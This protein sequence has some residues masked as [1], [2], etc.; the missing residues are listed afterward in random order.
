MT[1]NNLKL[2]RKLNHNEIAEFTKELTNAH[3][4]EDESGELTYAPYRKEPIFK[5]LYFLFCVDGLE[6]GDNELILELAETDDELKKLWNEWENYTDVEAHT[7]LFEQL[8]QIQ[9]YTDKLV[10][11]QLQKLIHRSPWE[12]IAR[13]FASKIE[14]SDF[15]IDKLAE[16]VVAAYLK[17]DVFKDNRKQVEQ[18]RNE[19]KEKVAPISSRNCQQDLEQERKTILQKQRVNH[20]KKYHGHSHP[21]NPKTIPFEPNRGKQ[22]DNKRN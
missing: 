15:N 19:I 8:W 11:Y 2:K 13:A 16:A 21:T 20:K 4:I 5:I 1:K 22:Y 12:Y 17:T 18:K 7:E 14:S 10:D 6:L 9:D 3:F